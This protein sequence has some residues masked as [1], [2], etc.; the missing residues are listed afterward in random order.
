MDQPLLGVVVDSLAFG[1]GDQITH[2]HRLDRI[3]EEVY[4]AIHEHGI[5][6]A[7]VEGERLVVQA[8]VIVRPQQGLPCRVLSSGT[9]DRGRRSG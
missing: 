9:T 5:A 2:R 6:A 4:A 7:A 8:D 3:G 1:A